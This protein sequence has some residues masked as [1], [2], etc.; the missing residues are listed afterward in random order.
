MFKIK[1]HHEQNFEILVKIL[2]KIE[3]LLDEEKLE[4]KN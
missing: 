2:K 4:Q 1:K 3:K